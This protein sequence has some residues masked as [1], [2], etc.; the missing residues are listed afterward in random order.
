[1]RAIVSSSP[2][3]E[4]EVRIAGSKNY[5]ARYLLATALAEGESTVI[6]PAPIDDAYA[7]AECLTRLGATVDTTHA[8]AWRVRG[9]GGRIQGPAR[10]N[11]RNAGAVTRFLTAVCSTSPEPIE[12]YTPYPE[13]LGRRPQQ[14][15]LDALVHLGAK[16]TSNDGRLPITVERGSLQAGEVTVAADKSS[17]YLSGLL[18]MAPLLTGTTEIH[19]RDVLRSRPA[20]EQTLDVLRDVGIKVESDEALRR[21]RITGP[22]AFQSGEYQVPGDWPSAA[23][24]LCAAAVV[25]SRLTLRGLF[26]DRQGESRV[27][28]VL[29]QMGVDV[30]WDRQAGVVSLRSSGVLRPVTVD[31]DQPTDAVLSMVAA[32]CFSEGT[33]RFYNLHTLRHKESD[34][35]TDFCN[36]LRK[37]GVSVYE[38]ES[39]IVVH[40][41]KG[42][43]PGGADIAAHHDHRILMALTIL[44]IRAREPLTL[45]D[46]EHVAKSYPEYFSVMRTLGAR[47]VLME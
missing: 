12:L 44:G 38:G 17:Q 9:V 43:V 25:E 42:E 39:E 28:D 13:S 22:Q 33:S 10:L 14:D 30:S 16:V 27:L 19:V 5:T 23:A 18:L 7:M 6:G 36:E 35:I 11:V 3:L 2:K 32:A 45:H 34:R 26:P 20:V 21:F 47:V 29:K 15:L 37:A 24:L 31:G 4:G 41:T 40:G 8:D 46:A 1:M